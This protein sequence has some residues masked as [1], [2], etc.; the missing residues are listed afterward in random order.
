MEVK[1]NK[2]RSIKI[3]YDFLHVDFPGDLRD[4]GGWKKVE[5]PIENFFF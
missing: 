2:L 3:L 5:I 1:V 4:V